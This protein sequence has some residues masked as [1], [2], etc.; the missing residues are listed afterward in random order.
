MPA[1]IIAFA[2]A[3]TLAACAGTVDRQTSYAGADS[4][5]KGIY[6]GSGQGAEGGAGGGG[7]QAAQ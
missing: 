2:L 3:I 5:K 6:D 7:G 4:W 1:L